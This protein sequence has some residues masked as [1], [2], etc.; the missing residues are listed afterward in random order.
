MGG[1]SPHDGP[2]L[3][4]FLSAYRGHLSRAEAARRAGLPEARWAAIERGDDGTKE[5]S[6]GRPA[7]S[8]QTVAAMCVA[9]GADVATGL[10]LAG[11]DPREYNYLLSAPPRLMHLRRAL[12]PCIVIYRAIADAAATPGVDPRP[13]IAAIYREVAATNR[14]LADWV[15]ES[16]PDRRTE[17]WQGYADALRAIAEEQ[18]EMA[19]TETISPK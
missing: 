6:V 19:D 2:R 16:P 14:R 10:K 13:T 11:H 5:Q 17:Y 15:R 7:V 9:V 18:S 8:A 12:N 1:M 3:G 4:K